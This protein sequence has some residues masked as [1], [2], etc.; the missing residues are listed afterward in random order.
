MR[1]GARKTTKFR[2]DR[3]R[4]KC[5]ETGLAEPIRVK[6]QGDQKALI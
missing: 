4:K 5:H 2:P 1:K 3:N 6:K